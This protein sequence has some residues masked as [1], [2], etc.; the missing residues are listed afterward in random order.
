MGLGSVKFYNLP[1][2][3]SVVILRVVDFITFQLNVEESGNAELT[4]SSWWEEQIF[5][6]FCDKIHE[7]SLSDGFFS[8]TGC[9]PETSFIDGKNDGAMTLERL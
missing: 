4:G 5:L 1:I 2:K 9:L 6:R 7:L 8:R 3:K